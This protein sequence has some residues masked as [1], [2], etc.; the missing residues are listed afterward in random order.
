MKIIIAHSQLNRFGGGERATLELLRRLGARHEIELWTSRY[1]PDSTYPEL[2][3]FPRRRLQSYEWLTVR[4]PSESVVVAGTFGA[5]LLSLRHP[6]TICYL[7]TLRSRFLVQNGRHPLLV[8]RRALDRAS[9]TNAARLLTNSVYSAG[10]IARRYG[11]SV[12]VVP[13]GVGEVFFAERATVGSYALYV[14]RLSPEKGVERL[15]DWSRAAGLELVV[16]GGGEPGFVAHLRTRA[17]PRTRFTGP[18]TGDA[19][20]RLYAGC[21]FL[22]F[23]PFEEEFGLAALEAMAGAK[24]V[25][26]APTGGLAELVTN[27]RTGFLVESAA[28]FTTA[29]SL[30]A[31]D[32]ALCLRLGEQGRARARDYTWSRFAGE[33]E[34]ACCEL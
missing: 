18:V 33:I 11:K 31:G 20:C 27:G 3:E 2:A 16:V 28:E 12:G 34:A 19:L 30:L 25:V 29:A 13:P 6:R 21:R 10:Q 17:G 5:N 15:L 1:Q 9:I 8:A 4:P 24:P 23:L 14:G 26:A 32:E 22:A 7:H